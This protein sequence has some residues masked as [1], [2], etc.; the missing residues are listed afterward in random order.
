[1]FGGGTGT[2]GP[3][4]LTELVVVFVLVVLG[5]MLVVGPSGRF[6]GAA[7]GCSHQQHPQL[8][9]TVALIGPASA[10]SLNEG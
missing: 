4:N 10:G 7:H 8:P 5:T 1:M 9:G 3:Q 2:I 6:A